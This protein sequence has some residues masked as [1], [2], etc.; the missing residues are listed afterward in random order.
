VWT[1]SISRKTFGYLVAIFFTVAVT[2]VL[3]TLGQHINSA[4]VALAL[5]LVVVFV[6]VEFGSRAAIV[7]SLLAVICFNFFF[8]PPVGTLDIASADNWIALAVFLITAVTVGQLSA[9]AK[10]RAEEADKARLEIERLYLQLQNSFE[11]ASRAKAL[12]QSERLKS[13]LLDAVTHDLRTP[14]TSIKASVTTLLNQRRDATHLLNEEG[15]N[16]MLEVIDEESDRLNRFI[17]ELMELARI[18][19]GE[20]QLQKHWGSVEEIVNAAVERAAPLTRNHRMQVLL[21]EKL[22]AVRVDERAVAEVIYNLLENAAKFAPPNTLI[23]VEAQEGENENVRITVSDEGPGVP[24]ELRERVFEKFFRAT[25]DGD[26]VSSN[27]TGTGMGLA[28]ARGI[29]EAHEG[30]IW[31]A[32]KHRPGTTIVIMLPTGDR[33]EPLANERNR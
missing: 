25:Q 27:A 21:S 26:S 13:A 2:G 10:R 12:E 18:E 28:I 24:E 8:L 9:R 1:E 32:D 31:I 16:E 33:E 11:Q 7:A 14:L 20:M 22:P 19:A 3:R 17:E 5:L 23:R 15:R 6:A 30:R 4:T 29:V